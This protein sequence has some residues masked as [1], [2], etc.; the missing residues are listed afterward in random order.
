MQQVL[1]VCRRSQFLIA[2]FGTLL[3]GGEYRK[4]A[5][6]LFLES[7]AS[8]PP[9]SPH[10][11]GC[12]LL[13]EQVFG[14]SLCFFFRFGLQDAQTPPSPLVRE[15]G[16]G[17]LTGAGFLEAPACHLPFQASGRPN[18]PFSPCGRRGLGGY[19]GKKRT[20]IQK[21]APGSIPFR[22]TT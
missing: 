7:N 19:E 5:H 14:K 3:P 6:V 20:G 16:W 17:M 21:T 9:A 22:I 11:G 2:V 13:R 15:R 18:A 1:A 10:C 8:R 12:C 4:Q